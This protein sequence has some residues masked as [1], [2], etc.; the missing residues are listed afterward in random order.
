MLGSEAAR[1]K[2]NMKTSEEVHVSGEG[3]QWDGWD[4]RGRDKTWNEIEVDDL[5]W[6]YQEVAHK[7]QRPT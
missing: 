7:Q 1:Q 3:G 6:Q 5:L 4:N 2:E